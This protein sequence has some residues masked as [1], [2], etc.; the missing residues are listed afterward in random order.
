MSR[1]PAATIA[2][3]SLLGLL[4]AACSTGD[5]AAP[6][7]SAPP[8]STA[9]TPSGADPATSQPLQ[10]TTAPSS[11]G[12]STSAPATAAPSSEPSSTG[13]G[14]PTPSPVD[15]LAG[16]TVVVDQRISFAPGSSSATVDGAV[17]R[18]ERDVYRLEAS[19]GQTMTATVVSLD[20]NAVF[21][22]FGPDGTRLVGERFSA[23]VSLPDDGDYLVVVGGTRGNASYE[24]AVSITT[25]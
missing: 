5:T 10:A 13:G 17:I 6:P 18:G 1:T 15:P 12:T 24:L 11:D 14:Q 23:E 2:L 9:E 21:D 4:A 3:V 19:A 20:D 8:K 7:Y 25:R 22:I 16:L